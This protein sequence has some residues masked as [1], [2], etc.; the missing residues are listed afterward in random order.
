MKHRLRDKDG[1]LEEQAKRIDGLLCDLRSV[2]TK[3][4]GHLNR[5]RQKH[6]DD[7]ELVK[8]RIRQEM[9]ETEIKLE[10]AETLIE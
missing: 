7:I 3:H 1:L 8:E 6:R 4:E 2:Q 10:A 9:V 5:I